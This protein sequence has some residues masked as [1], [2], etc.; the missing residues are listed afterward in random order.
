MA[1]TAVLQQA[2][3]AAPGRYAALDGLRGATL[4]SMMLYHGAWDLVYLFGVDWPWYRGVWGF[5]WQQSIC[6]TFIALSGFCWALGKHPLRRG[7]ITL[8]GGAAVS[9]A[10]A[11]F[12]PAQ[13]VRFGVLTLLGS[14]M[15]LMIPLEKLLKRLWPPAGLGGSLLLFC[16]TYRLGGGALTLGPWRWLRLPQALY[17]GP[18]AAF[19]GFTPVDFS[20]SDYFPLFPWLFLFAA[21]YFLFRLLEGKLTLLYSLKSPRAL[22]ALGRWSLWA[23]LLHQPVLYLLLSL[24]FG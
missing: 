19:L 4:L 20:S 14:C 18:V 1:Q 10:T 12:M 11:V 21:G 22:N 17:R 16:V 23:Y 13:A 24:C 8:G 15:L 2:A 6:W 9:L 7:L 5:V 3:P